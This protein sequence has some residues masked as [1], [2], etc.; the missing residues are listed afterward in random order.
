MKDQKLRASFNIELR[1][2]ERQHDVL[3][4]QI[5]DLRKYVYELEQKNLAIIIMM[6]IQNRAC[7]SI[8]RWW[9]K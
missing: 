6:R 4:E 1:E 8:N 5:S 9:I 7:A 2:N 3:E